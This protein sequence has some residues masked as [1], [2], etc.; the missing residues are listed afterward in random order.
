MKNAAK[1]LG[2]MGLMV[3]LA[4]VPAAAQGKRLLILKA[5]FSFTVEQKKM[6]AGSYQILVEHGWLQIRSDD[7]KTAAVVLTLPVAGKSPE[8]VGQVVFNHYG[9]QYFL[10]EVWLPG[11]GAGRQTLESREEKELE[12]REKLEAVVIKLNDNAGQ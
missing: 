5:P 7:N 4:A 11:M 1:F 9:N 2:W 8:S 10:S 12:K 3:T 6:P